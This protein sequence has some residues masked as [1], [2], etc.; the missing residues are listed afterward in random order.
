MPAQ[1]KTGNDG[2]LPGKGR[3]RKMAMSSWCSRRSARRTLLFSL[4]LVIAL[5]L[6]LPT[7]THAQPK[8]G[9]TLRVAMIGEP[10]TI[11]VHQSTATIVVDI[12]FHM[13]EGLFALD[14]EFDITPVLADSYTVSDDGLLYTFH[15]RRGV[16]FHDGTEMTAD[17]VVASME[18]WG[19][20]AVAGK[21]LFSNVTR[22][23]AVD[24][25]TVEL[26]LSKPS[27]TIMTDLVN[28]PQMPAIYPKSLIDEFGDM[29]ITRIVGTGPYKLAEWMPDSHI[30]LVR[31]DDYAALPGEPNGYGGH[32]A[33][34]VDE[35]YF[36]PVPDAATRIFGLE[37]GDYDVADWI[38]TDNYDILLAAPGVEPM[39]VKPKEWVVGAWN[40][41]KGPFSD[42]NLRKAAQAALDMETIM[43]A[44]YGDPDF[45]RIDPGLMFQEQIW[46]NDEGA[47]YY[48]QNDLDR[49]REYLAASSYNG[50]EIR[51]LTTQEYDWMYGTSLAAVDQLRAKLGLNI[52]LDVVDWGTL[53]QR[54]KDYDAFV[55]GMPAYPDPTHLPVLNCGW[56]GFYCNPEHVDMMNQL[57]TTPDTEERKAIFRKVQANFYD[58]A[59]AIKFGDFFSLRGRRDY[60]KGFANMPEPFFW[61][62]WLDR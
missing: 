11:D 39:I 16:P 35:I 41:E 38:P 15:L 17:D 62:T 1:P 28:P 37:A 32:K 59:A 33:A 42:R 20:I 36:Y 10:P 55:T 12:A 21:N 31:F 57:L 56:V 43:L 45:F 30:K 40:T 6:S 22:F 7:P 26:Q 13:V 18:R 58:D 48:N 5:A 14:S 25:Y 3:G 2:M 47:E 44:A 4:S 61:N 46:W 19:R 29:P 49:A 27:G 23:E 8:Y 9:G 54:R 50:E 34:Y 52:R 51:W 60:V 24:R 53:L